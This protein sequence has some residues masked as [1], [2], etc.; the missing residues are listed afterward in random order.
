MLPIKINQI[1]EDQMKQIDSNIDSDLLNFEKD[2][3]L[4]G[5]S[6]HFSRKIELSEK[7]LTL[8]FSAELEVYLPCK[9][10]NN[11]SPIPLLLENLSYT[12][13]LD[14]IPEEGFDL[15]E[16][17]RQE[18]SLATPLFTECNQGHCPERDGIA[19]YIK[20]GAKDKKDYFPFD[21]LEKK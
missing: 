5:K 11:L 21:Y 2:K 16:P 4:L 14:E 20:K 7:F 3:L 17:L 9:I 1:N 6:I 19:H 12:I 13:G 15:L 10:C 8:L 18:I